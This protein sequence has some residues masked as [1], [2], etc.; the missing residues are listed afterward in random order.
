MAEMQKDPV[1]VVVQLSGGN[2]YLNTVIPYN[3][4][5]YRDNRKAVS[6]GDNQI[7]QLDKSYGIPSYIAPMKP[8]WDAGNL[9]IMHGVG[10][11]DS[12][13][14]ALPLH[15]HLAHL[16]GRQGRHGRLARPGRARARS[17]K[18]RTWSRP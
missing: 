6:I 14:V 17:R 1:L 4:G 2:D 7:M 11:L 13:T 15:G 3:N 10:Y 16:R 9:A 18:R 8:F 12:P 5:L